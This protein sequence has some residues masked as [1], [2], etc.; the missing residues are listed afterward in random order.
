MAA[1]AMENGV[2]SASEED[3][4]AGN[5][6]VLFSSEDDSLQNLLGESEV[7]GNGKAIEQSSATEC[8][9]LVG[10]EKSLDQLST[11]NSEERVIDKNNVGKLTNGFSKLNPFAKEFVPHYVGD[12]GSTSSSSEATSNDHYKKRPRRRGSNRTRAAQQRENIRRTLYVSNIHKDVT[13]QE[14]ATLFFNCG[15]VIDCRICADP[16]SAFCFAFVE[17]LHES[18]AIAALSLSGTFV[19][20]FRVNVEHSKTAI[21]PVNPT[22]LPRSVEERQ[23]CART[24]YCTSI[25]KQVSQSDLKAFFETNCGTVS[26]MKW[27]PDHH[28]F[29][30]SALVEFLLADSAVVAFHYCGTKLGS[31]KIRIN[32]SKTPVFKGTD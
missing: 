8:G 24:I 30:R 11:P 1:N 6:N 17:F 31:F 4:H 13:E 10:K 26:C 3:I 7:D 20:C 9:E 16:N 2:F 18:S 21:A 27:L 14:L 32:P 22:F 25:D 28:Y 23:R 12:Q 29:T 19:G 15:Q 5:A